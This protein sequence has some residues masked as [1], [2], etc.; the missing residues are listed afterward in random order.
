MLTVL[1][2][3]FSPNYESP[4][5][6]E[7]QNSGRMA[8]VRNVELRKRLSTYFSRLQYL[9]GGMGRNIDAHVETY[10]DFLRSEAI[11]SGYDDGASSTR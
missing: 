11:G 9:R 5:F 6:N 2:F 3:R 4:T 1:I 10:G 8:L 7:L